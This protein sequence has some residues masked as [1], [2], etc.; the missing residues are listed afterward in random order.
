MIARF[1]LSL[2]FFLTFGLLAP[3]F[4]FAQAPSP[5]PVVGTSADATTGATISPLPAS[6][7]SLLASSSAEVV[8]RIQEKSAQDITITSGNKKDVFVELLEQNPIDK[9]QPWNSLQHAIRRAISNGLPS[10]IVVLVLLFPMIATFI[11]FSRHVIGL[12]G[13]G[14][15][16]P[17]VLSV[18]FLSTGIIPGITF[19]VIVLVAAL[20]TRS[21]VKRLRLQYLPRTAMLFLGVSLVTLLTLI[22]ASLIQLSMLVSITIF[23]LLIII[24]LTENFMETQLASSMSEAV[25]L[26]IETLITALVC[27][28]LI[29]FQPV[30]KWVLLQPEMVLI[31]LAF[32]NLLIGK[33]TGLRLLE[34]WRFRA[35]IEK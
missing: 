9:L 7:S 4:V 2:C 31:G 26:T 6:G 18:A 30:Q 5:S 33:Y 1:V 23:P 8:Q 11:A 10:N 14:I 28:L 17:A 21:L 27:S 19:F 15:Y 22:A 34:W 32:I 3:A 20:V 25:Q 24:L 13:F 29:G 35:I 12:K 16:S